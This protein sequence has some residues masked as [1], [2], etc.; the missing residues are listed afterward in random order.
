MGLF[1]DDEAYKRD[2]ELRRVKRAALMGKWV[3]VL[4]WLQ[5]VSIVGDVF[6]SDFLENVPVI[7]FLGVLITYGVMI[8]NSVILIRLKEVEDWF[9]KAGICY[10]VS[11]CS[12]L[13]IAFFLLG[14]AGVLATLLSLAMTIVALRG[15]YNECT[16]YEVS[17]QDVDKTLS[18]AWAVQWKL[19]LTCILSTVGVTVL[20]IIG[21]AIAGG[22]FLLIMIVLLLVVAIASLVIAI[23]RLI[24]IYRA[25]EC[26]RNYEPNPIVEQKDTY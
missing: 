9:G 14:G 21:T 6:S 25:A 13:V 15:N 7:Y 17:L 4:F 23:R 5:I 12:G 18:E 11:G 1:G 2:L 20:G 8:A 19:E 24:Y 3:T 22:A 26:F 10:L 16:G